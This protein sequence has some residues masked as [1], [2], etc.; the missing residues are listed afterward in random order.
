MN[1]LKKLSLL[2]VSVVVCVQPACKRDTPKPEATTLSCTDI[3]TDTYLTDRFTDPTVPDYII[4]CTI[5]VDALLTIDPGVIIEFEDGA[6]LIIEN[7]G[8]LIARGAS[9][10]PIVFKGVNEGAGAWKGIYFESYSTLNELSYVTVTG[11][12]STSFTTENILANIRVD[13]AA[14]LKIDYCTID[15]SSG[16]G[17]YIEGNSSSGDNPL[18]SFTH[19]SFNNNTTCPIMVDPVVLSVIDA[20]NTFTTNGKQFIG[21]YGTTIETDQQWNPMA[22]PFLIDGDMIVGGTFNPG[23]VT[24]SAGAQLYFTAGSGIIIP[25]NSGYLKL[26]GSNSNRIKVTGETASP[27][28]WKGINIQSNSFSNEIKYADISYGGCCAFPNAYTADVANILVGGFSTGVLSLRYCTINGSAGCGL[29]I[30]SGSSVS[31]NTG[32]TYSGNA[33]LSPCN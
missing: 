20:S 26:S 7:Y 3:T 6:G 24:V 18:S 29:Q 17:M 11:G 5:N 21:L 4:P 2:F 8:T 23:S 10:N 33:T 13:A 1:K 32:N 12:G 19:N 25:S 27:G 14:S 9:I 28:S 16:N 31:P 22:I 30:K 15:K